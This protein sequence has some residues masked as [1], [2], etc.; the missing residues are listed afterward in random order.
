MIGPRINTDL[1]MKIAGINVYKCL[2]QP[3]SENKPVP[4]RLPKIPMVKT[5]RSHGFYLV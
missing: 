5:Q 2:A 3:F 4:E 1:P